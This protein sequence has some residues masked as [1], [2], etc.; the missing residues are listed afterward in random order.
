MPVPIITTGTAAPGFMGLNT[1]TAGG[2]LPVE[3]STVCSNFVFDSSGRIASRKGW[4][5]QSET[6]VATAAGTGIETIYEYLD[7]N[8]SGTRVFTTSEDIYKEAGGSVASID[9][10][11]A[12]LDI[13]NGRWKFQNWN[14]GANQLLLGLNNDNTTGQYIQWNGT[15][16]AA[17]VTLSVGSVAPDGDDM[18]VAWGRV[19]GLH[20]N[21]TVLK[22][23]VPLDHTDWNN[24][25]SGQ[26]DLYNIFGEGMDTAVAISQ[27]NGQLIIFGKNNILIF[28]GST[29]G[30]SVS[31][32]VGYV[33]PNSP[34]FQLVD[35]IQGYGCIARDSIQNTGRDIIFLSSS[36][37]QSLGRLVQERSAPQLEE[38]IHVR[39]T[40]I[41]DLVSQIS[42]QGATDNIRSTFNEEEGFYLLL[43]PDL[44]TPKVY[45]VDMRQ[46]AEDGGRRITTWDGLEITT[47]FTS[48]TSSKTMYMGAKVA[49]TPDEFYL[50]TYS[51]TTDDGTDIDLDYETG[52]LSMPVQEAQF[53]LIIPKSLAGIFTVGQEQIITYK[54]AFDF[55]NTFK[56][57]SKSLVGG[58]ASLYNIAQYDIDKYTSGQANKASRINMRGF[59][60][61]IKY[62]FSLSTGST[63]AASKIDLHLKV[64]RSHT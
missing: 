41:A 18:M 43:L 15:G 63:F 21:N 64:G 22:Y 55:S 28:G 2:L 26:I 36:G 4:T 39:D 20:A 23:S 1:Q 13:D 47:L 38:T 50:A 6:D 17:K 57:A 45:V 33:D 51:G 12:N 56:T 59:G 40:L 31:A 27:F 53:R 19:W 10:S 44:L 52:W 62:G 8:G 34:N 9:P 42:S 24:P 14:D 5:R 46:R 30:G 11:D 16:N 49:A 60:E 25:G 37:V 7:V 29:D 35:H 58:P 54:W 32:E 48:R 3:W 61:H